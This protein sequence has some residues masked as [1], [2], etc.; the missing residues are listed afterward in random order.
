VPDDTE[1]EG[2]VPEDCVWCE[3]SGRDDSA[4]CEAC[5]GSGKV[6]VRHPAQRCE[7]CRGTGVETDRI[8]NRS[9]RCASCRGSGWKGGRKV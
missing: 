9:P 4:G 3:G 8:L 2:F 1:A 5:G 6:L 7:A